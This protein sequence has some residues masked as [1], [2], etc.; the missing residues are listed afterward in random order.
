MA[1]SIT[2]AGLV[3][4]TL[5][6]RPRGFFSGTLISSPFAS[7]AAAAAAAAFCLYPVPGGRPAGCFGAGTMAD[8]VCCCVL[9][10]DGSRARFEA[11]GTAVDVA[12]DCRASFLV[13]EVVSAASKLLGVM[14]VVIVEGEAERW[15]GEE[16]EG[17]SGLVL[18]GV[19]GVVKCADAL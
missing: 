10:F 19:E 2:A 13:S 15:A 17:G 12:V 18:D 9:L 1:T 8:A 11:S 14:W 3:F 6:G 5:R 7:A 4:A 16:E